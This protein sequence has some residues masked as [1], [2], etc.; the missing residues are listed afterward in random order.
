MSAESHVMLG[1]PPPTHTLCVYQSASSGLGRG[2][3]IPHL[4]ESPSVLFI[5]PPLG[6]DSVNTPLGLLLGAWD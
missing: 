4:Q 1:D 5:L 6:C 2:W 3:E